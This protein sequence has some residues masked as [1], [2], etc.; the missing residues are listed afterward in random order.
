MTPTD[1]DR[2]AQTDRHRQADTDR[3][4]QTD[5]HRHRQTYSKVGLPGQIDLQAQTHVVQKTNSERTEHEV[6]EKTRCW[7]E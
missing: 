6:A 1:T 3:Q 4:T 2:Q 7:F 5:R